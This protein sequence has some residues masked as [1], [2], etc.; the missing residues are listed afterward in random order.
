MK[1]RLKSFWCIKTVK[2]MGLYCPVLV[3]VTGIVTYLTSFCENMSRDT[4]SYSMIRKLSKNI[5]VILI[6][7]E[8][9]VEE[10]LFF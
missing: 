6:F 4:D 3:Y 2:Q 7:L 5:V 10:M 8:M 1:I 9:K